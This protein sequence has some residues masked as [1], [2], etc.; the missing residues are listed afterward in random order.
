MASRIEAFAI[1]VPA[2]F[3]ST[4]RNFLDI[5]FQE[6][7]VSRLEMRIPPGPSGLVGVQ[8]WHSQQRLIPWGGDTFI[9]GDNESY[10]WQLTDY[11]T[12]GFWTLCAYNSDIYDHT[13]YLRL[14][15]DDRAQAAPTPV[16]IVPVEEQAP[17]PDAPIPDFGDSGDSGDGPVTDLGADP[18]P[19]F[20]DFVLSDGTA[21]PEES[22]E[23]FG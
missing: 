14:H 18:G 16:A 8:I 7:T 12:G 19:D 20:Y 5:P 17:A 23:D 2:G 3:G 13:V 11:P 9:I 10:D 15:V 6:G 22:G 1:T 4:A 21:A